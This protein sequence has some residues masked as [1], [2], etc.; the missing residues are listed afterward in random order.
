M[1]KVIE[2]IKTDRIKEINAKEAIDLLDKWRVQSVK[3]NAKDIEN[4]NAFEAK[5]DPFHP[6]NFSTWLSRQ[7]GKKYD[8]LHSVA[9][10]LTTFAVLE[11]ANNFLEL[12][13]DSSLMSMDQVKE[14]IKITE[15]KL[16]ADLGNH[17]KEAKGYL[18]STI[19][20]IQHG[21]YEGAFNELTSSVIPKA[22]S[23]FDYAMKKKISIVEFEAAV[24]AAKILL[25]A[26]LLSISYDQEEKIF[27]PFRM[28]PMDKKRINNSDIE[29][30]L[31]DCIAHKNNVKMSFLSQ[32]GPKQVQNILNTA[33]KC[34]YPFLSELREFTSSWSKVLKDDEKITIKILPQFLPHGEENRT[35]IEIGVRIGDDDESPLTAHFWRNDDTVSYTSSCTSFGLEMPI[36]LDAEQMLNVDIYFNY[37]KYLVLPYKGYLCGQYELV[38]GKNYYKQSDSG[39]EPSILSP[40]QRFLYQNENKGWYIGEGPGKKSYF[41]SS[42]KGTT[43]PLTGWELYGTKIPMTIKIGLMEPCEISINGTNSSMDGNYVKTD[44]WSNGRP[45]YVNHQGQILSVGRWGAWSVLNGFLIGFE[46]NH[47]VKLPLCPAKVKRWDVVTGRKPDAIET[48]KASNLFHATVTCTK[49]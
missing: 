25:F 41:K 2:K 35:K 26:K 49:C 45:V 44:N 16:K 19:N 8:T 39:A 40:K 14:A 7:T 21:D 37:P 20:L 3:S 18:S 9:S 12:G 42:K 11:L 28:I 23:A 10:F 24:E 29:K 15:K 22:K 13:N 36:L 31:T 46:K 5:T 47:E 33:L 38:A 32:S 4:E 1:E 34:V 17:L 6:Q 30:I 43:F 27:L 48:V